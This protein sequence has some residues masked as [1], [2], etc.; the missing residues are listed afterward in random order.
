ML[1]VCL[2]IEV[3]LFSLKVQEP[4]ITERMTV[5]NSELSTDGPLPYRSVLTVSYL[6]YGDTGEYSCNYLLSSNL[7]TS[8]YVYVSGKQATLLSCSLLVT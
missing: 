1:F 6:V 5:E 2:I 3:Y 8:V 7:T 4:A